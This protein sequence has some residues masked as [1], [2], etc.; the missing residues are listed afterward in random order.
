[1]HND[2]FFKNILLICACASDDLNCCAGTGFKR[3]M[4]DS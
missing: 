1:M 2:T 3:F 4:G